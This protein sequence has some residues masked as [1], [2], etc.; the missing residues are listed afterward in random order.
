M[1][2]FTQQHRTQQLD[3]D[4]AATYNKYKMFEGRQYTGMKI[5]RGHSWYYDKGEW[6][7]KKVTPD[8]WEFTYAV[9]KRRKG[10][11]PEGSGVPVGTE[12]HWYILAHQTVR[13]LNAN[14]YSTTMMGL[15]YKLAHRRAD[16]ENWSAS[17]TAQRKRLITILEEMIKELKGQ[18]KNPT[19]VPKNFPKG[20]TYRLTTKK[21][22]KPKRTGVKRF[23]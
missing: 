5:G 15:K 4:L 11:A 8:K 21:I 6:K 1:V 13:K 14:D 22:R 3:R 12:Y 17:D 9:K 19:L 10:H 20:T 7:E 23:E 16:H 2:T 18:L